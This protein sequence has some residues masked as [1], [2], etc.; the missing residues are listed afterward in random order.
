[1][2]VCRF[3]VSSFD[4]FMHCHLS[5]VDCEIVM[6]KLLDCIMWSLLVELSGIVLLVVVS[7][8]SQRTEIFC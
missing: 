5:L 4:L 1:M 3:L 8:S 7:V 6:L 2:F